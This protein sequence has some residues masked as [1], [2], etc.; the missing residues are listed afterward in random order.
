MHKRNTVIHQ[1]VFLAFPFACRSVSVLFTVRTARHTKKALGVLSLPAS[2]LLATLFR[3]TQ[4]FSIASNSSALNSNQLHS[5]PVHA[6]SDQSNPAWT[7]HTYFALTLCLNVKSVFECL[8][9][10]QL[11]WRIF[12]RLMVSVRRQPLVH[13]CVLVCFHVWGTKCRLNVFEGW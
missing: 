2:H 3:I 9:F 8:V 7:Q 4:P 12:F 10:I 13:V 5:V 11:V 1:T 6:V